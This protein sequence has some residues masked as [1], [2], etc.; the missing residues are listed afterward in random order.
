MRSPERPRP[1]RY[2]A[3]RGVHDGVLRCYAAGLDGRLFVAR[4]QNALSDVSARRIKRT[5]SLTPPP[6]RSAALRCGKM[7]PVRTRGRG[8]AGLIGAAGLVAIGLFWRAHHVANLPST[9][10]REP[11]SA[12]TANAADTS[13]RPNGE[14][15]GVIT[16]TVR[17]ADGKPVPEALVI[18]ISTGFEVE[19]ERVPTVRTDARGRF[20]INHVE[21]GEYALTASALGQFGTFKDGL[22]LDDV[23][24]RIDVDLRLAADGIIVHGTV[25]DAEAGI[26]ASPVV[27]ATVFDRHRR[28]KFQ[29]TGRVDGTYELALS[30]ANYSVEADADGYERERNLQETD[31]RETRESR[32]KVDFHLK[33]ETV[34]YG[35]VVERGSNRPVTGATVLYC[36]V[37]PTNQ[38]CVERATTDGAGAFV[39]RNERRAGSLRARK[40]ELAGEVPNVTATAGATEV[41]IAIGPGH[42]VRGRVLD[43]NGAPIAN[44]DVGF[45]LGSQKGR[46]PLLGMNGEV[47]SDRDGKYQLGG[48]LPGQYT[49][50]I[51]GLLYVGDS[52]NV[53]ISDGDVE[54]IDLVGE[55]SGILSG[56]LVTQDGAPV[57]RAI[58]HARRGAAAD[59]DDPFGITD[60]N[61]SF[62][63]FSVP[64]GTYSLHAEA[65]DGVA[66][67][68]GVRMSGGHHAGDVTLTLRRIGC[69]SGSVRY[70]D[71][72]VASGVNVQARAIEGD[73]GQF[74]QSSRE[75]LYRLCALQPGKYRVTTKTDWFSF[76]PEPDDAPVVAIVGT[77]QK[78]LDLMVPRRALAIDGI[79]VDANG[80]PVAAAS[81]S[82]HLG[83]R[84][85]STGGA[86]TSSDGTFH[87]ARLSA[88]TYRLFVEAE[89]FPR[90][91][92]SDVRAGA[93]NVRV[94][95]KRGAS[96]AGHVVDPDGAAIP[97]FDVT[98]YRDPEG[99]F[100]YA[101][102]K[103]R[104]HDAQGA[105][106]VT[107]LSA[108]TY[109]LTATTSDG[110]VGGVDNIVVAEGSSRGNLRIE[111]A[112]GCS[113]SGRI[114]DAAT[115][116][117]IDGAFVH[118]SGK[119][120]GGEATSYKTGDFTV[121]GLSAGTVQIRVYAGRG[122]LADERSFSSC[123]GTTDVGTIK[124]V[125]GAMPD[126]VTAYDGIEP[127]TVDGVA[128]A[129]VVVSGS[130]ADRA[131]VGV[132]D[133]L[134][135]VNGHDVHDLGPD[136]INF[137]LAGPPGAATTVVYR[138]AKDGSV[139]TARFAL[140]AESEPIPSGR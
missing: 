38:Y 67:V 62:W 10:L 69:I 99:R 64:D 51:T 120:S 85:D 25:F 104:F 75:G 91:S 23:H 76:A 74:A 126:P 37:E 44:V 109:S 55:R 29:T 26:V 133:A 46:M 71:G 106:S 105:F 78:T 117:P 98:T 50:G 84:F 139:H 101:D 83:E 81:I 125:R 107:G 48:L 40:D 112:R 113:I 118:A 6:G 134:L 136:A 28:G 4:R 21:E 88:G 32:L 65:D 57:D 14:R 36:S 34:L 111:V 97:N 61:G 19:G 87:V 17:S 30:R 89:G 20:L 93:K 110:R 116:A 45:V 70:D 56:R 77:E 123:N 49:V 129:A 31:G 102:R 73:G 140:V 66:D 115:G 22:V 35:R 2:L 15:R 124:L 100:F 130:P 60:E 9:Q 86:T 52:R 119:A 63:I 138:S 53:R 43:R 42:S 47:K 92:V 3:R 27:T 11:E 94:Q 96:L 103:R 122:V 1:L 58:V 137:F 121:N 7:L 72:T 8:I 82:A 24:T 54:G 41:V 5:A 131:G 79:V 128:I 68:D 39:V 114:V 80:R 135:A 90:E 127:E 132:R 108:G 18:L 12:A 59:S 95:L 16:G 33:P 13:H